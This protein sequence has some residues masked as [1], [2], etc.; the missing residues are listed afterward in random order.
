[1][2]AHSGTG[3]LFALVTVLIW[4]AQLPIAKTAL[5]A[6]VD[7]YT[8]SLVRYGLAVAGLLP[9]LA[10]REGRASLSTKG[11]GRL[12]IAAGMFGMGGS[13]VLVFI[14]LEMTRPETAVIIIALQPAMTAI[15]EWITKGR[16]PA[17]FTIGCLVA[18]FLGVLTVV[19]RGGSALGELAGSSAGELIGDALVFCGA[20]AWVSYALLLERFRGWSS[21]RVSAL[22]C[23]WGLVLIAAAWAVALAAGAARVPSGPLLA[24]QG[25][26]LAYCGLVGVLAAMFLW[27]AGVRRAGALNAMLVLSLMPVITFAFRAMEGARFQT[28]ELAGAAVVVGS[29]VANNLYMR[30]RAVPPPAG[31]EHP[32]A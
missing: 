12:A 14:G 3:F 10:W 9:I 17:G 5:V 18:A 13:A 30:V 7:G 4:G 2:Q 21:L 23:A 26:R 20:I 31:V 27:N 32:E 24:E 16:R 8:M 25:W 22:T 28:V 19:T 15:G 6:G 11:H 1:M 29:L